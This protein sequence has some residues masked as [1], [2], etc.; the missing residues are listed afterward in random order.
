MMDRKGWYLRGYLEESEKGGV[1]KEAMRLKSVLV[2]CGED[3]RFGGAP[4]SGSFCEAGPRKPCGA[5]C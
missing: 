3:R 4:S 5:L 1:F 2:S